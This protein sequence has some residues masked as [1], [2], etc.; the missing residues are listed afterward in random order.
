[1]VMGGGYAQDVDAIVTIHANTIREA[2]RLQR[3]G[4]QWPS[5][6]QERKRRRSA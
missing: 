1:V 5:S 2:V 4:S 3:S 6:S